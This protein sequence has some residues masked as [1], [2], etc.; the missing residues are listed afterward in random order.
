M[1][2]GSGHIEGGIKAIVVQRAK[3][4]GMHWTVKGAADIIALRCHHASGRWNDFVTPAAPARPRA[5]R[6]HLT[7]T[8]T[9]NPEGRSP[10]KIIPNKAVVHPCLFIPSLSTTAVLSAWESVIRAATPPDLRGEVSAIDRERPLVTPRLFVR[11]RRCPV[12]WQQVG[13]HAGSGG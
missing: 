5:P 12:V 11:N 2:T 4:S 6:S 3:Q 10:N 9:Q 1:F 13:Q 8:A 7:D